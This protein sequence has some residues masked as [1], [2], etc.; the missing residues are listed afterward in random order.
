MLAQDSIYDGRV[1]ASIVDR[2]R[3][4]VGNALRQVLREVVRRLV[5]AMDEGV[6]APPASTSPTTSEAVEVI[7]PTDTDVKGR[8]VTTERELAALAH[9][10]HAYESSPVY[11]GTLYDRSIGKEVPLDLQ[12]KDTTVYYGLY[13]NKPSWWIA[14]VVTDGRQPWIAVNLP[15]ERV[16]QLLPAGVEMLSPNSFGEARVAIA[17]VEAIP[18]LTTVLHA[19]MVAVVAERRP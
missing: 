16:A 14:R 3:P 8:I 11:N 5:A 15:R 6:S 10:R 17:S 2:F 1:M 12:A 13:F 4:I 18:A 19:A 9:V 7:E